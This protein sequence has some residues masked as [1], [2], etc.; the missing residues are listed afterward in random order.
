MMARYYCIFIGGALRAVGG[1][2]TAM[3]RSIISKVTSKNEAGKVFSLI[4]A[5]LTVSGF[6][7]SPMY[8]WV[9]NATLNSYSGAYNLCSVGFFALSLVLI[10]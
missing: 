6:I 2:S 1:A 5:V 8:T 3:A 9:Y 7:S 4:S 10:M